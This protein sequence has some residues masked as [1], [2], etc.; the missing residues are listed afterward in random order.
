L[1]EALRVE[2][3]LPP[4]KLERVEETSGGGRRAERRR[5]K[6]G[7]RAERGERRGERRGGELLV[8]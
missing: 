5:G 6:R 8:G 1:L 2:L 3:K 4:L 7:R